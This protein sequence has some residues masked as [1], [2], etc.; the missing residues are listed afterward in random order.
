MNNERLTFADVVLRSLADTELVSQFDRLT[1]RTLGFRGSL[2]A[3][4]LRDAGGGPIKDDV[5]AFIG[6]V[7][8]AD[9]LEAFVAFVRVTIWDR[10]PAEDRCDEQ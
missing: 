9:D 8:V 7:R 2:L 3:V 4:A 6:T 1:G 10:M 5:A